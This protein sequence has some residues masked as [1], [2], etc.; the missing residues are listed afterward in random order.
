MTVVAL[1]DRPKL[2]HI[3]CVRERFV[4]T[5]C[6]FDYAPSFVWGVYHTTVSNLFPFLC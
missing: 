4:V 3:R 2:A 6:Y 1:T 5:L